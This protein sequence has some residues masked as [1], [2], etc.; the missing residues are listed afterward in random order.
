MVGGSGP[1][2]LL[3]VVLWPV[4][5]CAFHAIRGMY[6]ICILLKFESDYFEK[7]Y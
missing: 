1:P 7:S 3:G 5:L 6:L 2:L 4:S